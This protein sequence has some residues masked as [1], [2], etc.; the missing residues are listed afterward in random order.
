MSSPKC[1]NPW[2]PGI[3]LLTWQRG[4]K[5]FDGIKV[6]N[7]LRKLSWIMERG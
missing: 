7:H 6:V 2:I 3:D 5:V 1:P 4:I